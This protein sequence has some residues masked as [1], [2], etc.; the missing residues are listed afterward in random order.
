MSSADLKQQQHEEESK[1]NHRP[2]S[3][4]TATTRLESSLH[5]DSRETPGRHHVGE[6]TKDHEEETRRKHI[7]S[8]SDS[9]AAF[10]NFL[11][12]AA[13]MTD[14]SITRLQHMNS[15][16]FSSRDF[17]NFPVMP[18]PTGVE[19]AAH[20]TETDHP[21]AK[22]MIPSSKGHQNQRKANAVTQET[23]PS[24]F[25]SKEETGGAD[26]KL[27]A[28]DI[29]CAPGQETN[30]RRHQSFWLPIMALK[31]SY[32]AIDQNF[33]TSKQKR[34][35]K[36]RMAC[37]VQKRITGRFLG[38]HKVPKA[39]RRKRKGALYIKDEGFVLS[40][41]KKAFTDSARTTGRPQIPEWYSSNQDHYAKEI[42]K[43][44]R[45]FEQE[46]TRY[47]TLQAAYDRLGQSS[48]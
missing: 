24:S 40:K 37:W 32:L 25:D 31:D 39:E 42:A 4:S 3:A 9:L 17:L 35:E 23:T 18:R 10:A 21:G 13:P 47:R 11:E 48:S 44:Q 12:T 30:N 38:R 2:S 41:I 7:F 16:V 33:Q 28:D 14:T 29:L 34:R 26:L 36:E 19:N 27:H 6:Q 46:T 20:R 1:C 5:K 8:S 43:I 45:D 15:D 22:T